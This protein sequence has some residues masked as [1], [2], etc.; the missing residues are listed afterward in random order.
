MEKIIKK[1]IDLGKKY[2]V[3]VSELVNPKFDIAQITQVIYGLSDGL[4]KSE[5]KM[6]A[7]P[8]FDQDQMCLIRDGIKQGLDVSIYA[9]PEF[10]SS[11]MY[12]IRKGLE[13]GLDVSLYT[14]PKFDYYQMNIIREGLEEGL[15]VS[16]YANPKFN[17][18]KNGT[19]PIRTWKGY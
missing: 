9:K 8:N 14:N 5:V 7:N 18:K 2:G 10:A 3:D 4:S 19:N 12:Q 11:Q 6:Y 16:I 13:E 1:Q 15:D 17:D